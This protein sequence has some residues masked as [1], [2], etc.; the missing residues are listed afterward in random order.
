MKKFIAMLLAIVVAVVMNVAAF[1]EGGTAATMLDIPV[2]TEFS[3]NMGLV[4]EM[5]A[6]DKYAPQI[7]AML[8]ID[9]VNSYGVVP[10]TTVQ[11][12]SMIVTSVD[13]IVTVIVYIY[14]DNGQTVFIIDNVNA[15][16]TFVVMA[17]LEIL[18][19]QESS[20]ELYEAAHEAMTANYPDC[21]SCYIPGEVLAELIVILDADIVGTW[22]AV[23][24][25]AVAILE[26]N[27]DGS[28]LLSIGTTVYS[29]TWTLD[30]SV[31][32]LE[33]NGVI[34]PAEYDGVN[35]YLPLGDVTLIFSR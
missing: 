2:T 18:A 24:A 16:M 20:P 19:G 15:G 30:G 13:G 10:G 4:P 23:L 28:A 5:W 32:N 17:A 26:L 31:L 1:A 12:A 33:Q 9:Y 11:G 34:I 27:V 6:D 22:N 29:L 35:V 3:N 7:A 14:L 25:D 8:Y 21:K